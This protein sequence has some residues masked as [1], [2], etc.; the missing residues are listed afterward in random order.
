M[1]LPPPVVL[2]R[3]VTVGAS[4]L[5]P[6]TGSYARHQSGCQVGN[7]KN[8]VKQGLTKEGV[9]KADWGYPNEPFTRVPLELINKDRDPQRRGEKWLKYTLVAMEPRR[10]GG[11][12]GSRHY[13][14]GDTYEKAT[15]ACDLNDM[16]KALWWTCAARA[17]ITLK[18]W[19]TLDGG[20]RGEAQDS[21]LERLYRSVHYKDYDGY[22][23]AERSAASDAAPDGSQSAERSAASDAERRLSRGKRPVRKTNVQL[24]YRLDWLDWK[25]WEAW[26]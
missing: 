14:H 19:Y 4:Y 3:S 23:S 11:K 21:A 26:V 15:S 20:H 16:R 7:P 1:S 25:E 12:T 5:W 2:R 13:L 9:R 17:M 10:R 22:Q 24:A 18:N 6:P 8:N